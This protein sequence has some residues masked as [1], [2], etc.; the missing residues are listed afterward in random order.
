M[1]TVKS[2]LALAIAASCV[3]AASPALA[4]NHGKMSAVAYGIEKCLPVVLAK[5]PGEVLQVVLK[6]EKGDAT[7]E[8]EIEAADG[9]LFDIEC[10]G[11][12]GKITEME[13]RVK[14]A[15]DP[16]FKPKVKVT[17][18]QAQATVLAKFPGKVE[19]VEFEIE[20]DGR[21]VYE[22]DIK[23][24]KGPDMRVEVDAT[25]GQITESSTELLEIG[26]L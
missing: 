21:V 25:S 9:K 22:F 7:W 18:E 16:L 6:S 13:T 14:T 23:P 12:T 3:F 24:A 2:P 17:V 26:R 20:A 15:D 1:K 5:Q 8:V 10:S 4:D 11:K 19:R